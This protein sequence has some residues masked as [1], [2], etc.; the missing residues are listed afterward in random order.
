M[1]ISQDHY[2]IRYNEHVDDTSDPNTL[3]M[4]YQPVVPI[5]NAYIQQRVLLEMGARSLTELTQTKP[6]ISFV[7]DHY[8][9][10][11]FTEEGFNVQ[12]V[13]PTRTFIEKVLLLHEE[14]SKPLDKIRID[15]LTR[16]FYDLNKMM[17]DDYKIIQENMIVGRKLK[18]GRI[19]C[20]N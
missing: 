7:D 15:R 14:F 16:H 4:Y 20:R 8:K 11:P 2:K 18:L 13:V 17:Q 9:D 12:V 3:E 1:G 10:L 5:S 19:D 6:F